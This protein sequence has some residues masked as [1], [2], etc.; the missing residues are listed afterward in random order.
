ML[1][2]TYGESDKSGPAATDETVASD[3]LVLK[4]TLPSKHLTLEKETFIVP[5]GQQEIPPLQPEH[6]FRNQ[7]DSLLIERE[8]SVDRECDSSVTDIESE[9]KKD[10]LSPLQKSYRN[11][12]IDQ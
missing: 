7:N 2:E 6:A 9:Y 10:Q 1:L 12:K 4:P 3:T 5:N 8:M 11:Q